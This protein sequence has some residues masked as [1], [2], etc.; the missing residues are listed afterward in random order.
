MKAFLLA[1][2]LLIGLTDRASARFVTLVGRTENG[3]NFFDTVAIGTNEVA[4]V[5][6]LFE[7][8]FNPNGVGGSVNVIIRR[9][10]ME[11]R[12]SSPLFLSG[13]NGLKLPLTVAGPATLTLENGFSAAAFATIE[14]KTESFPPDKTLIIPGD[15]NGAN[16][17]MESS[18]DLVN[19]A[20]ASPG[21]YTNRTNNLFFRIRAERLP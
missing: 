16:V 20:A 15:S 3:T 14:V 2:G 12:V 9:G 10:G 5:R 21:S 19:W 18:T 8:G 7:S 4:E 13:T 11:F 6:S 1:L 17:I